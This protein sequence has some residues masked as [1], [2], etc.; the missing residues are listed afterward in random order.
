MMKA[1]ELTIYSKDSITFASPQG[2]MAGWKWDGEKLIH[3]TGKVWRFSFLITEE[4][5]AAVGEA[6][7]AEYE[8]LTGG[9]VFA[10]Y[11]PDAGFEYIGLHR[12]GVNG[13]YRKEISSAYFPTVYFGKEDLA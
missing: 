7:S 6:R 11:G 3:S 5:R 12:D 13:V 9:E 4:I 2:S 1:N 10:K 8:I